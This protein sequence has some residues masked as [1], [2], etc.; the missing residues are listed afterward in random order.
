[1]SFFV[2]SISIIEALWG[3]TYEELVDDYFVMYH[4]YYGVEKGSKKYEVIKD[5]HIDEM[6]KY[7]FSFEETTTLL[8][9]NYHS[10]ANNYLL[11]IGLTQK[12]I[13]QVQAKL[14]K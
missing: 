2:F 11:S 12:Q 8:G 6:I 13:D 9:A 1:M 3:T 7:V 5:L 14:S 10:R 4:N